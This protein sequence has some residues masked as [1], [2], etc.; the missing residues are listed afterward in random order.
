MKATRLTILPDCCFVKNKFKKISKKKK[1]CVCKK[2]IKFKT[3]AI[4]SLKIKFNL[5]GNN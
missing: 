4:A 3:N 1:Y 5:N 2:N